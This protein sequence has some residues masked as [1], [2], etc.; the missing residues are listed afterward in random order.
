MQ[1][2][3]TTCDGLGEERRYTKNMTPQCNVAG[4][5]PANPI[6][7]HDNGAVSF[8]TCPTYYA[9]RCRDCEG[10][11]FIQTA[12]SGVPLIPR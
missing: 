6:T 7:Y 3:C 8:S 5:A 11:G 2:I 12:T 9:R 4:W 10:E 1:L